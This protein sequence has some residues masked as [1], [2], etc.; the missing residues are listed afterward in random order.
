MS[1]IRWEP[2]REIER[3]EPFW[4]FERW[5]PWREMERI[6]QRM[7]RLFERLMPDGGRALSFGVPVAEMEETDSEIR[8][9]LEVPGLE[10]KD[11]NIEVTADSVSISGE[12]K[13]ATKTEGIGVTRS[14]FYY[15][16]FERTIPLPAHIQTDKVQAEYKNGVL[17]LTMPKTETEKHKVVKVSVA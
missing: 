2:F 10:A 15:G 16:K 5:E 12:R 17:S 13:S 8:L 14:E 11:L 9:K 4:E 1:L 3:W 7:N 6:Q